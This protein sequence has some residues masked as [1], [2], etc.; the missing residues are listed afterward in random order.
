MAEERIITI[1]LRK[2]LIKKPRWKKKKLAIKIL[3]EKL[4]RHLKAKVKLDRSINEKIFGSEKKFKTKLR[5]KVVKKDEKTF[6]AK[7]M[8]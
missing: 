2:E 8:A 1:N 4:E 6:E 5:I 3:R 7:L